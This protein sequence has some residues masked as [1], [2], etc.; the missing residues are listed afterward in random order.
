MASPASSR[1]SRPAVRAKTSTAASATPAGQGDDL[2]GCFCWPVL[3]CTMLYHL[4]T[5]AQHCLAVLH[6]LRWLL[7]MVANGTNCEQLDL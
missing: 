5:Y 4:N 6:F 7:V 2:P 3:S 1:D